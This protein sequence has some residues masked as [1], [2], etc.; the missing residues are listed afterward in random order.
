MLLQTKLHGKDL[1]VVS[2]LPLGD[3][4]DYYKVKT[5][6]LRAYELVPEA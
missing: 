6:V 2:A 1:E 3:S 5:T 4:L